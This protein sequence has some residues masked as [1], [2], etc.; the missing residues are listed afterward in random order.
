[1]SG[2]FQGPCALTRQV[3]RK[4]NA[5]SPVEISRPCI[6]AETSGMKYLLLLLPVCLESCYGTDPVRSLST[7]A[8]PT[9][10]VTVSTTPRSWA[11]FLQHLPTAD[12]PVVDYTGKP[13][14]NQSKH[15]A[16]LTY[17]VGKRDLQQC[18]DAL[19]RLRAE[20]LFEAGRASEIAFRFTSGEW[21]RYKEY[22]AG[23][24]PRIMAGRIHAGY[25]DPVPP[26]HASMRRYLDIVYAFAGTVS[27][28]RDL[29]P[30]SGFAIGTVI[31]T[32]GSPGHCC[33]VV[34]QATDAQGITRY[35]LVESYMPAQSIYVLKNEADGTPWHRLA[36]GPITTASYRFTDYS[37]KKFE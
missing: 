22:L 34:D 32:P 1:M 14:A 20:Y 36:R 24:R 33:L 7:Q 21:F 28:H 10:S 19:I 37:L 8:I 15:S 30:A 35:K 16:V 11:F 4:G 18:A 27:L 31:I 12:G 13:I 3:N 9:S 17:D 29:L 23:L 6:S 26:S 25:V 5:G 2:W